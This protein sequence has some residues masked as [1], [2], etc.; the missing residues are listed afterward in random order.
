MKFVVVPDF[1]TN[2]TQSENEEWYSKTG[3]YVKTTVK[4]D[5]VQLIGQ[6]I[7]DLLK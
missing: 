2:I 1:L 3:E 7:V 5:F 4:N 6:P